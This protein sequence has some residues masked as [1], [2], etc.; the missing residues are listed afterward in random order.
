M[1]ATTDPADLV[2]ERPS[3]EDLA[4]A[5]TNLAGFLDTIGPHQR[6]DP[7]EDY[8]YQGAQLLRDLTVWLARE[9]IPG[10]WTTMLPDGTVWRLTPHGSWLTK[11]NPDGSLHCN[12]G[13]H[14]GCPLDHETEITYRLVP[15]EAES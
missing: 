15:I 8:C 9:V 2:G 6:N 3:D 13:D 12:H 7:D 1:S 5:L 10:R 14:V 4:L 11:R